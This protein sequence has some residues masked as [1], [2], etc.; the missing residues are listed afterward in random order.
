V[1]LEE[2]LPPPEFENIHLLATND[3]HGLNNGVF[4][5]RVNAWSLKLFHNA[6]AFHHYRPDIKLKYSEQSGMEEVLKEVN[7]SLLVTAIIY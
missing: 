7:F 6:L 3:R 5:L 1:R 4:L 2:F